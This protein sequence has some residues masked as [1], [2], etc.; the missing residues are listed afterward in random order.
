ML[1]KI[2]IPEKIQKILGLDLPKGQNFVGYYG[3]VYDLQNTW[4]EDQ[5]Y[6]IPTMEEVKMGDSISPSIKYIMPG[7]RGIIVKVTTT[8][9]VLEDEGVMTYEREEIWEVYVSYESGKQNIE[10]IRKIY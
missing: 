5:V 10:T 8:Y 6:G 1:Y 2:Y 3:D 9:E 4:P 7:V